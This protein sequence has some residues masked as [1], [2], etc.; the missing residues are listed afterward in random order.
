M[1]K[2]KSPISKVF[3]RVK[4]TT[5]YPYYGKI[6]DGI[7]KGW[8]PIFV[9][10]PVHPKP[11]FGYFGEPPNS[12]QY[13]LIN[14]NRHIYHEHLVSFLHFKEYLLEVPNRSP[15]D[16]IAPCWK[17]AWF[18]GLD[19]IALY[20]FM[21]MTNPGLYIEIGSGTSTKF[22]RKAIRDHGLKTNVVSIDPSPRS[23]INTI[24]DEIIRSPLE[25]SDLSVFDRL[26]PGDILFFDG[27]H[28]CFM[29][30]DV[31]VFFLEVL[32]KLPSGLLI[33]IHDIYLPYD[34]P[35]KRDM[36]YESEQYLIAAMLLGGC[37]HYEIVLANQF[38]IRDEPLLNLL[39]VFWSSKNPSI[40]NT[41]GTSLWIRKK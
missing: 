24:S 11:R 1:E 3:E 23:E 17:N 31:T 40:P 22:V 37:T 2:R 13:D 41:R 12:F 28:R 10:Y 26:G 16:P 7:Q 20:S 32:P 6:W 14:Q 38:I 9:K 5:L 8:F 25:E 33:H 27:S 29:N 4:S 34:Y 18:S 39:D 19:A 21:A 30:S 35:P 36:H 15:H